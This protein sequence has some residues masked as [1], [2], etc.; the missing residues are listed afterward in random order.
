MVEIL[1]VPLIPN[2]YYAFYLALLVYVPLL[3]LRICL[4]ERVMAETL[5][6]EYLRYKEEVSRFLPIRKR[7]I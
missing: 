3:F 1:G 6:E 4:E 7:R 5:G 2:S